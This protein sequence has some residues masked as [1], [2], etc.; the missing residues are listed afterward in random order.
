MVKSMFAGVSG[1]RT[2]QSKMNVIGNNIANCNT[3]GFKAGRAVFKDAIYQ[4][5]TGAS[6]GST[7]YGGANPTQ[8]GYGSELASVDLMF[9]TGAYAPTDSQTD[10]MIDG[11][12]FFLVGPKNAN[13]IKNT[14]DAADGATGDEA[15]GELGQ[16]LFTRVGDFKLDGDGYLVDS[17]KNVVYGF[18][19]A[20]GKAAVGDEELVVEGGVLRPIRL[21]VKPDDADGE[22]TGGGDFGE[23]DAERVNMNSIRIDDKGN[24]IGI[25]E[26]TNRV[27]TVCRL[28]IANVPNA[29][30]LEKT[31]GPYYK[32]IQNTGTVRAYEPGK[33]STGLV[34]S[35]GL[36]MANVDIAKEFSDMITT[37]RGF[38]AN[39]K[40]ITVTDEMLQELVNLKR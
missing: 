23:A 40:I 16:L 9:T 18:F 30:A 38:Q 33:G 1:L 29:N 17:N 6:N 2:H 3:Y 5:V 19:A 7:T 10:C 27:I 14:P 22:V 34:L 31:Q 36:E 12:G 24:L 15:T 13:G 20:D 35:N 21:P 4:T 37:Q 8:V 28:A 39:T 26:D 32:S 25:E 11:N